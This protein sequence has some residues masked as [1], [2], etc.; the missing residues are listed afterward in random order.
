[1][2]LVT[3]SRPARAMSSLASQFKAFNKACKS[4]NQTANRDALQTM[5]LEE[6]ETEKI[7]F[8]EAKKGMMFKDAFLDDRWTEFI[9]TRFEKSN[10]PEHMMYVRYVSL[11]MKH[12][13][14]PE[15]KNA[16]EGTKTPSEP[17]TVPFDVWT[18]IQDPE[19]MN[20]ISCHPAE[21][22]EDM[23]MLRQENQNLAHRMG[24]VEMM[25]QEVLDHL[26]RSSVKT[27]N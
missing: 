22:V 14:I 6:L 23:G 26:R 17:A 5:T 8:G 16:K 25:M 27:E 2:S 18:E 15:T 7:A 4:A 10:K 13:R 11:R 24:Q 1:M 9:L 12:G 19:P 3:G 21:L 20:M